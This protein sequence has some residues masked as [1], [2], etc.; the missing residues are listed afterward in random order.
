MAKALFPIFLSSLRE[1]YFVAP[2][3]KVEEF[4]NDLVASTL[5]TVFRIMDQMLEES[6]EVVMTDEK[7]TPARKE[8]LQHIAVFIETAEKGAVPVLKAR[9]AEI[10][11]RR[12]SEYGGLTPGATP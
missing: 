10:V 2:K 5:D 4:I 8:H 12:I 9:F 11:A 3:P 6:Y 1:D 7:A